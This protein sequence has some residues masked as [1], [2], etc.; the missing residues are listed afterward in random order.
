[1]VLGDD[2]NF[3][4]PGLVGEGLSSSLLHQASGLVLAV[5]K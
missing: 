4:S 1:M 5:K 3:E 2:T